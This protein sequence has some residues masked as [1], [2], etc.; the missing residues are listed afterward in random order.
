MIKLGPAY[1]DLKY[2]VSL[3]FRA[4]YEKLHLKK[5]G[6][7]NM[8]T[9]NNLDILLRKISTGKGILFAGAGFSVG[10]RN[11]RNQE[12]PQS[13]KLAKLISKLGLFEEDEDLAFASDYFITN[14]NPEKLI[15]LLK[16]FYTI[17]KISEFHESICKV[18]WTRI[19]TTNY[20]NCIEL[21]SRNVNVPIQCITASDSPKE[22][23]K[24]SNICVH[25]NGN[26]NSLSK[27]TL[28]SNFKLSNSSYISPDSFTNSSWY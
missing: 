16:Q 18:N 13:K 5:I 28:Q 11:L 25:L 10:S 21:S 12:P 15:D 27:E 23:F 22:Y 8:S 24:K 2:L 20:D 6:V 14:N 17:K 4:K 19:H 26:I 9:S 1:L 7:A 3:G